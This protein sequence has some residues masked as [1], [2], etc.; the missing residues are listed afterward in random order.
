MKKRKVFIISAVMVLAAGGILFRVMKGM[1][2]PVGYETRPAVSVETPEIGDIVLYTD[3]TGTVEPQ[4][5][6][7]V[8]PKIGGEVL[9]VYF[10]AGDQV[11]EGQALCRIDSDV[12]TSLRLQMESAK[13]AADK[14]ARESAR[15]EPLYAE[16]YVSQPA[17]EQVR[18]G[19][20]SA[21]LAYESAKHQ[22]D[23]QSEYTT[24]TASISGTVE[25]RN[26]EPHD[27]VSPEKEICVISSGT[28]SMIK[29]GITEKI[30]YNLAVGDVVSI[31]KNGIDYSGRVTEVSSMVSPSNGLYDVKA[32]VA[33]AQGLASGTK[34]KLTV[35]MDRA[36]GVITVP[37]DAVNY[38][39]GQ[40][41]VYCYVDGRAEKTMIESGIY[42]SERMEVKSGLEPDNQV[43]TSWS[44]ELVDGAEVLW[45]ERQQIEGQQV[46]VQQEAGE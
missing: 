6:A 20:A 46:E 19:A 29:F 3:L 35:V 8:M 28:Q 38:M 36:K 41:F 39:G 13:M 1:E 9:E 32:V 12:L 33:R 7:A 11:Q 45:V 23:Q 31:M 21:R 24:V 44:N 43:I 2:K 15:I 4:S 34:V 14:A 22:Y 18:D 40:P 16:G 26:V 27:Y 30:R 5:R 42:D 37:V 17:M 25:A 10:Q